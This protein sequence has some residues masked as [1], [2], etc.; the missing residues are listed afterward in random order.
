MCSTVRTGT[1]LFKVR[2][3]KV[4]VS[5]ID[6]SILKVRGMKL[7]LALGCTVIV[8]V[9]VGVIGLEPDRARVGV[10]VEPSP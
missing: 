2:S 6:D 3:G 5:Y 10:S 9:R 4:R 7:G 1:S 8:R